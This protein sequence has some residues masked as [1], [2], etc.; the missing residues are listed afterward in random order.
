MKGSQDGHESGN[1]HKLQAVHLWQGLTLP[2]GPPKPKQ[3][4]QSM[5][6]SSGA[7]PSSIYMHTPDGALLPIMGMLCLKGVSFWGCWYIKGWGV[8]ELEYTYK[9][10][11][12]TIIKGI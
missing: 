6:G 3:L 10:V 5:T 1:G 7:I 2:S 12:K 8:R 4:Q 9:R 11:G